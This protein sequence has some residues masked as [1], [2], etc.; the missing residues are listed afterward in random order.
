[1]T[2]VRGTDA[3]SRFKVQT[4]SY[5]SRCVHAYAMERAAPE[6]VG[7]ADSL[8]PILGARDAACKPLLIQVATPSLLWLDCN[9]I[10]RNLRPQ[11]RGR[12]PASAH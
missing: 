12:K 3:T 4:L 10:R 11:V 6:G 5:Q 9:P 2:A 1:V 8:V 7:L